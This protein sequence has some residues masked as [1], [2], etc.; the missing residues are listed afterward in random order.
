[1]FQ[2]L[3]DSTFLKRHMKLELEE[4]RRKRW[5]MQRLHDLHLLQKQHQQNVVTS[6]TA[7]QT[8]EPLSFLPSNDRG[9]HLYR[10]CEGNFT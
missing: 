5:D 6:D 9:L 8:Q 4:K 3:N 7:D 1:M 2:N 10:I